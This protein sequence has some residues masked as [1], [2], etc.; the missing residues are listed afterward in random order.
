MSIE[1][2]DGISSG[3]DELYGDEQRAKYSV[4]KDWLFSLAGTTLDVGSGTGV[5]SEFFK[6]AV[7]SDFSFGMISFAS[8]ARVVCDARFLP[9][10]DKSFDNISCFTVLQDVYNKRV[11]V[12]EFKRVARYKLLITVLK[13]LKSREELEALF[14]GLKILDYREEE[15]DHCFLLEVSKQAGF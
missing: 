13:R 11:V 6:P 12:D 15:K 5:V 4:V 10:K 2:Y 3:Y 14:K 7:L 1:Y 8:G 9:F